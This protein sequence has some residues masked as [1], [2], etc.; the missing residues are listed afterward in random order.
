MEICLTCGFK[1]QICWKWVQSLYSVYCDLKVCFNMVD[2]PS[3][4]A[5]SVDIDQRCYR[6]SV[7]GVDI[8][9]QPVD[10]VW[11]WTLLNTA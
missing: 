9:R 10:Y 8:S 7:D 5:A 6:G 11:L 4:D 1:L 3:I 2:R